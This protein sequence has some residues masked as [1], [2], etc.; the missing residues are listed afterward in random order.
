MFFWCAQLQVRLGS[1][2]LAKHTLK[3]THAFQDEVIAALPLSWMWSY[4]VPGPGFVKGAVMPWKGCNDV[5]M[6]E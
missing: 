6:A 5:L 4:R 1:S 3:H 2:A